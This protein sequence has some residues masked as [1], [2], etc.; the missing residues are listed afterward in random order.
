MVGDLSLY[1]EVAP[2]GDV[3]FDKDTGVLVNDF[4]DVH[5]LRSLLVRVVSI[6]GRLPYYRHEVEAVGSMY[7]KSKSR[8]VSEW[9]QR[10]THRSCE[11]D[12]PV[13]V[14]V[15]DLVLMQHL[16]NLEQPEGVRYVRYD[17]LVARLMKLSGGLYPL[18]GHL[19]LRMPEDE[20]GY[21]DPKYKWRNSLTRGE[22]IAQ[23]CAVRGYKRW[24]G[25]RDKVSEN[26]VG[27]TVYFR[28][29][30]AVR[31]ENDTHR[32]MDYSSPWPYYRISKP[33][34]LSWTD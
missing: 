5:I 2:V 13:E 31:I 33:Q 19:L 32:T 16:P 10:M 6:P 4:V 23:G 1:V 11:Y 17:Q 14:S 8:F 26:W 9:S 3:S 15:G 21:I 24:P 7:K 22:V 20:K 29:Y 18:N 27:R 34:I 25:F 12:V 28:P 30:S